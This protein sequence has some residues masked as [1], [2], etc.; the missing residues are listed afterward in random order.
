MKGVGPVVEE[1]IIE[2]HIAFVHPDVL[3]IVLLIVIIIGYLL[4]RSERKP[5]S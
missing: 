2:S 4:V 5:N 1:T 3:V